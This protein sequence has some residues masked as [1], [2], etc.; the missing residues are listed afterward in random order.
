MKAGDTEAY[1]YNDPAT[2]PIFPAHDRRGKWLSVP[3][4][5]P[6]RVVLLRVWQV[7]VGRACLYLLDTNHSLN[8]ASDRGIANKLYVDG[9]ERRLLQEIVLGIGGW[10]ALKALGIEI[11]VL[12]LNEGHA[13]FAALERARDLA[14]RMGISFE[15]AAPW[16]SITLLT[17]SL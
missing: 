7:N 8:G 15:Q 9:L 17:A 5:L 11:N 2:L 3:V 12:H 16:H 13:A 4:E 14:Q 1:P 10:R 6:G